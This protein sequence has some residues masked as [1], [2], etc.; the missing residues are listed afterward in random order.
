MSQSVQSVQFAGR[1]NKLQHV[2]HE[3]AHKT[4]TKLKN[5]SLD[6]A[7]Y[8]ARKGYMLQ[9]QERQIAELGARVNHPDVGKFIG[10]DADTGNLFCTECG[11]AWN[12]SIKDHL[13]TAPLIADRPKSADSKYPPVVPGKKSS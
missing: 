5:V 9:D 4:I 13:K 12:S 3:G 1:E 8:L 2:W 11:G 6:A 10:A 7:D